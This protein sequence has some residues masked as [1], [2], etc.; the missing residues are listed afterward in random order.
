M[1][2]TISDIAVEANVSAATVDRVL[3]NRANVSA[4]TK[5]H[6]LAAAAKL[7]YLPPAGPSDALKPLSLALVLP[8]GT[9]AFIADLAAE[10]TAQALRMAGVNV[11]V[12][13][14]PGLDAAALARRITKLAKRVDGIAV[15]AL[16]HPLIRDA[17]HQ[18]HGA[19]TPVVTLASDI[20]DAPRVAY[21]GIDNGQAGRLAGY[22]MARFLGRDP[23]G[24]VALFA[25][26]LAYRGHQEREMG[27]RQILAEAYPGLQLLELRES[28]ED[29]DTAEAELSRLLQ[30]HPDCIAVYNA[31]GGTVGVARALQKAGRAQDIVAIAHEVTAETRSLLLDG[32]LDAVIDQN[33][34]VEVREALATLSA[35]ARGQSYIPVQPRLQLVMRENLPVT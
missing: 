32:T 19:S 27:F 33:A 4:R 16:N 31:G 6:V 10:A 26:S 14:V 28:F 22:V 2:A 1:R 12:V 35:A 25:G 17:I 24:K 18:A 3:N 30:A 15:V 11:E 29:R 9:N 23:K 7:G 34:K 20:T 21:I 8:Y 5:A 13:Q